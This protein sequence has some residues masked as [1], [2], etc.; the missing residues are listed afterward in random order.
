MR[1]K[2]TDKLSLLWHGHP[3]E[4]TPTS[5]TH[6][7]GVCL[8][9]KV[10]RGSIPI[11]NKKFCRSGLIVVASAAREVGLNSIF[12]DYPYTV[13]PTFDNTSEKE[14]VAIVGQAAYLN[15]RVFNIGDRAVSWIRQRDLHI[16]TIGIMTYTNDQRFQSEHMEGSTEWTLKVLS[17]QPR[18]A[19]IYECQVSTEPKISLVYRLNVVGQYCDLCPCHSP[20]L[21][22]VS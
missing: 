18:D 13:Q 14:V 10:R 8:P 12:W 9:S 3:V 4:R 6:Y 19:G 5:R 7:P 16:L 20:I 15:C 2:V 17:P 22:A 1:L 11:S 21:P